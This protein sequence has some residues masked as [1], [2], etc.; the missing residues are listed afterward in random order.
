MI[1]SDLN[2][3]EFQG[4]TNPDSRLAV[5]FY[6]KAV[7]N[8]YETKQQGHPI[9]FNMD[10]VQIMVPGD[11]KTIIDQPARDDH[12]ARFPLQWAHYKNCKQDDSH[13]MGTPLSEWPILQTSQVEELRG[14]KF[15]TVESIANASDSNIQCIGMIAGMSPYSFRERAQRFLKVAHEE[16]YAGAV[17]EKNKLLEVELAENRAK[18]AEMEAKLAQLLEASVSEKPKRGRKPKAETVE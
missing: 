15:Y 13:E 8:E 7:K 14:L 4:A 11:D 1:A 16:A 10:Y 18:M 3:P 2:N 6:T 17:E 12:K 9:F 5:R